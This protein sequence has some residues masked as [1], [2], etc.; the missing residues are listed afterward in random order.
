LLFALRGGLEVNNEAN[1]G[2]TLA[3]VQQLFEQTEPVPDPIVPVYLEPTLG[4]ASVRKHTRPSK[5]LVGNASIYLFFRYHQFLYE[6]LFTALQLAAHSS[7]ETDTKA[8]TEGDALTAK[9]NKFITLLFALLDPKQSHE[10]REA[11]RFEDSC[12]AL[13]GG[14]AFIL[15]TVDKLVSQLI[16]S[17]LSALSGPTG[18]KLL[19]LYQLEG[20]RADARHPRTEEQSAQIITQYQ[21]N[22]R[23][24]FADDEEEIAVQFE[25]FEDT[26]ELGIGLCAPASESEVAAPSAFLSGLVNSTTKT[27]TGV[28]PSAGKRKVPPRTSQLDVEALGL[29]RT[30]EDMPPHLARALLKSAQWFATQD[31]KDAKTGKQGVQQGVVFRNRMKM[32]VDDQLRLVF[33]PGGSDVLI[34]SRAKGSRMYYPKSHRARQLRSWVETQLTALNSDDTPTTHADSIQTLFPNTEEAMEVCG[35]GIWC[36]MVGCGIV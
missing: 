26:K 1:P 13:L 5:L 2:P 14:G 8:A 36:R 32:Q 21:H 4:S 17:A 23:K 35:C 29:V 9:Q 33:R 7:S 20:L 16:K 10:N 28:K 34:R 31:S 18:L 19:T 27:N 22:A 6:R 30:A 11:S 12:R 25:F 3:Q 24:L 15:F